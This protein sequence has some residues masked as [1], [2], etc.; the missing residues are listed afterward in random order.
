MRPE[1]ELLVNEVTTYLE[2]GEYLYLADYTG[3]SV[4]ETAELRD[5]LFKQD[6][7]FHV[8]KNS[9][10]KVAAERRNLPDFGDAL[11]GPTAIIMGGKNPSGVAKALF[12][13]QKDKD[14]IE[15]KAGLLGDRALTLDE[16]KTLSKLPSL[17][18][19]RA[20]LLGLLSTPAQ[21]M[22]R[23]LNAVPQDLINVLA[24]K[25]HKDEDA[26]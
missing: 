24:A 25:Q 13:F 26:A 3:I 12:A 2:A 10:F 17:D 14:K 20:Q 4:L 19:L 6:A 8:V 1:K 21:Q 9:A 22:V 15:I 16:I 11:N 18:A 5:V 23:V 7:E